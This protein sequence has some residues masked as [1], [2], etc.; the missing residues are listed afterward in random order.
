M[1]VKDFNEC[2]LTYLR[3]LKRGTVIYKQG[4]QANEFY[5]VQQGL[6]G[7]YHTLEN[8]KESLL[9]LYSK[10]DYFGVRTLLGDRSY[11]CN[12]RVLM[13]AEII[14][15]Q[16][17]DMMTFIQHNPKMAQQLLFKL[18]QELRDAEHRLV[19]I[20]YLKSIDRVI[21]SIY[22]LN[23]TYPD[24]EW[25]YRDIA[26]YA[27]CEIETAIRIGK[28]LKSKGLLDLDARHPRLISN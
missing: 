8:G 22:F 11:H 4:A 18:S 10:D 13:P 7:L 14:R 20:S 2:Q 19:E 15:I 5:Y 27:G 12:A 23:E 6:I 21:N 28:A 3:S 17:K 1:N 26:E 25:T 24:Y 9:R 16:P